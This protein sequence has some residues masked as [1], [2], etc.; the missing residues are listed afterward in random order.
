MLSYRICN[1][2]DY[3][4]I[5]KAFNIGFSDYIIKLDLPIETFIKHFFNTEA[6]DFNYTIIAFDDL[7][8]I[9]VMLGG[10]KEFDGI[11]T[12]RCG[13]LA[14]DPE[15]RNKGIASELFKI[16]KQIAYDN[17]CEQLFLEVIKGNDKAINFYL[18][19]NYT[20][21]YDIKYCKQT[22]FTNL[23]NEANNV[24]LINKMSFSDAKKY[25]LENDKAHINWQNEFDYQGHFKNISYYGA[26]DNE[27]L[28]GVIGITDYGKIFYLHVNKENR[29]NKVGTTLLIH[30][31]L[32]LNLKNMSINFIDNEILELFLLKHNFKLDE[33]SQYEMYAKL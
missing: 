25:Y 12:M 3:E 30:S 2:N 24:I 26:F 13:A 11:K 14:V 9:G 6:N 7:E 31:Y 18:K 22:T 29:K 1:E 21:K 33:L 20:I 23:T 15:Y 8:P 32:E 19:N 27:I 10:I 17:N 4:L 5:Y 28:I 16:H